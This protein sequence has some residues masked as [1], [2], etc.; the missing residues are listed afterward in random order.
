MTPANWIAII[1]LVC[2]AVGVLLKGM[3][4]IITRLLDDKWKV[5][6]ERLTKL[7]VG[8]QDTDDF[9]SELDKRVSKVETI[10]DLR[11]V[12]REHCG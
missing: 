6:N 10:C 8:I 3:T 11:K 2:A 4:A 9:A 7:E 5:N 12:A 1:A